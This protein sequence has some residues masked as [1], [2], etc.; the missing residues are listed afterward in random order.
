MRATGAMYDNTCIGCN[1]TVKLLFLDWEKEV[2]PILPGKGVRRRYSCP[3]LNRE[4]SECRKVGLR[5]NARKTEVMAYNIEHIR[6][7]IHRRISAGLSRR[8]EVYWILHS[9]YRKI[10]TRLRADSGTGE[11]CVFFFF[12][13]RSSGHPW[14]QSSKGAYLDVILHV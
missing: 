14:T 1:T 6:V 2:F 12:S 13:K 7:K 8:L 10:H 11:P 4:E 3:L 5:L 9:F